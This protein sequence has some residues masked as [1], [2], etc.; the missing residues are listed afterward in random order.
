MIFIAAV[1]QYSR[2]KKEPAIS[3]KELSASKWHLLT[4]IHRWTYLQ[5]FEVLRQLRNWTG[6]LSDGLSPAMKTPVICFGLQKK[7]HRSQIEDWKNS[8]RKKGKI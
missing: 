7:K 6:A 8:V 3:I 2:S 5:Y 1:F 4:S